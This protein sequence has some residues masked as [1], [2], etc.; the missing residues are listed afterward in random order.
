MNNGQIY[1]KMGDGVTPI[2]DLPYNINSEFAERAERA[3]GEAAENAREEVKT[4][5]GELGVVQST[6]DSPT[7]VMSQ[8][9][10][11]DEFDKF[12]HPVVISKN[13]FDGVFDEKGFINIANDE[14]IAS[15]DYKYTS[16]YTPL[17]K[18][19]VVFTSSSVTPTLTMVLYDEQKTPYGSFSFGN[20]NEEQRVV[21]KDGF[22]RMYTDRTF[23]GNVYIG[24][25]QFDGD[26]TYKEKRIVKKE[27][28]ELLSVINKGNLFDNV[29]DEVGY[30]D[31]SNGA[32]A[33]TNWAKRTSKFY[34]FEKG[35][36]YFVA[37]KVCDSMVFL[38]YDENKQYIGYQSFNDTSVGQY[39]VGKNGYFRAYTD[40]TFDAQVYM[41]NT[42]PSEPI[43]YDY[44]PNDV[45]TRAKKLTVVNFG[46]SIFG[47]TQNHT[48]V[49]AQ[50]AKKSGFA[51]FNG[52]F[53]G[54]HM[55]TH[56]EGWD[57]CS[58]YRLAEYIA[59]KDFASL[60][61]A[62]D[63]GWSGMPNYFDETAK[64][65]ASIDFADVDVITIS[66]GT[67]D[68]REG[69]IPLDRESK[70]PFVDLFDTVFD[71]S[72]FINV[73]NGVDTDATDYKRTSKY[74]PV[75]GGANT[76]YVKPTEP[77][78]TFVLIC[79]GANKEFLGYVSPSSYGGTL[80]LPSGTAYFRVYT[81]K[82][83]MGHGYITT[84]DVGIPPQYDYTTVCGA[85]R[86]SIKR[87]LSRYP[88]IKFLVTTPIFRTFFDNENNY[89]V[90]A[91]SDTKDWGSGTLVQYAEAIKKACT[92]M[93]VS[94]LDL[95][96]ESG[97]NEVTRLHYFPIDDGTHP[98]E[99]GR[100]L[101]A[102]LINGKLQTI[103]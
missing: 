96:N 27:C 23:N 57:R 33:S 77:V 9:A 71:E 65:L 52:G 12:T 72:G 35:T 101:M 95:Y 37:S 89:S 34:P 75:P 29:F 70:I 20:D 43:N 10:V 66:Y 49:S 46:D 14:I 50:I 40:A 44:L 30:I 69:N 4:L 59:N 82:S 58:M 15:E 31:P 18:G 62:T 74:Y 63:N 60:V 91:Y 94:C 102:T 25:E 84:Q 16:K 93:K 73:S 56:A 7:A 3:A 26:Y 55:S 51:V 21:E 68:Y 1:E 81:D 76:V 38:F 61:A 17:K 41:S 85:L 88:H 6:G 86:Y 47:N 103:C 48:S 78:S 97:L 64:A 8:K 2:I 22:F 36:L 54:C 87:I 28:L 79:Y 11:T 98:N 83:F 13:I 99:K 90:A 24:T 45:P 42:V 92:D 100:E 32:D 19:G 53:G 80:T 39:A 67:N 5:V